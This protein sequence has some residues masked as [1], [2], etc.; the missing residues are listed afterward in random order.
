MESD[1]SPAIA[2]DDLSIG[3]EPRRPGSAHSPVDGVTFT[4]PAG[5]MLAIVGETGSGKS[6][7]AAMIA[8]HHPSVHHAGPHV[9]GGSLRV[10]GENIRGIRPRRRERLAFH[11][12]YVPQNAASRLDGRQTIGDNV[13]YPI[14]SRDRNF[15]RSEAEVAVAT[16]L[17][18]VRLPLAIMGSFPHEVS[19]GQR[20]RVAIA[21][22]LIL[23]PAL[24][25]ADDPTAGIDV[26]SRMAIL[27]N[28]RELQQ[29]RGF[30]ALV[31]SNTLSEV[32]RFS[33][34]VAIMHRGGIVGIGAVDD[35]LHAPEHSYIQGLSR[36][37]QV[38]RRA[39][40]LG[41]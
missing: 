40:E 36:T 19:Q 9:T 12:G 2:A 8:G 11:I 32:R 35:V 16:V 13:A 14:Y 37:L 27:D 3:Y 1:L 18:A 10:L 25:V 26:T 24:L 23:E 20:Q 15:D 28:I 6:T 7:L 41:I 29:A 34:R 21:Q 4:L 17:D 31:I 22:A 30:S 39:D 38:L 33:D 5:S